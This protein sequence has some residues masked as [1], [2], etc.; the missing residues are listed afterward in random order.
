M[1]GPAAT[2]ASPTRTLLVLLRILWRR[3]RCDHAD[4]TPL[5]GWGCPGC[6]KLP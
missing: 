1:T 5:D 4:W 3:R 6:G 2:L